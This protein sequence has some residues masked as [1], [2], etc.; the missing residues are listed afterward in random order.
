MTNRRQFL[1][2][3]VIGATWSIATVARNRWALART[4]EAPSPKRLIVVFLRGAV[5]GLNVVVPY[6]DPDYYAARPGI[7]IPR[8]SSRN[9]VLPLDA[10]FGM[11]PALRALLPLWEHQQLAFVH[12]CGSP[13]PTRSHFDAQD[14]M[15]SGTP[16]AKTTADGWMNR[17]LGQLPGPHGPTDALSFTPTLPRILRGTMPVTNELPEPGPNKMKPLDRP[18]IAE[19]FDSL[20]DGSDGLS[21]AYQEAQS[22]RQ[23]LRNTLA[24]ATAEASAEIPSAN[25]GASLVQGFALSAQRLGRLMDQDRSIRLGFVALGGW[26][27][28]VNQGR[29]SGQLANH[30]QGLADGLAMLTRELG[31]SF[32]DTTILVMSEFGRTVHENGNGGTDHGHGNVLW[33]LS[34]DLRGRK[35]YGEWPGLARAQLYEARDLAVTTD[36]REVIVRVIERQFHLTDLA[37]AAIFPDLASR[38]SPLPALLRG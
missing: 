8:P 12:A 31:A 27:T 11:H 21:R 34:G 17:L 10:Y 3:T 19:A 25:R 32:A 36:F 30:L 18:R 38:R 13:D 24:E 33:L 5:D 2:S 16:G 7:S 28:H 20:Y 23:E 6:G 37:L 35:V 29:D 4:V 22:A 26:D 9:G 14:Y 1:K 15:E